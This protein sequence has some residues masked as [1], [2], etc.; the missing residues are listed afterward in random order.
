MP[1]DHFSL[2]VPPSKLEPLVQFLI[3]SLQHLNF[4]EH[5]RPA[6]H[7][8]GMGESMPYFWLAALCSGDTLDEEENTII[9]NIMEKQHVA[10]TAERMG[11]GVATEQVHAFW[12]AAI[13]AGGKGNGPPGPRPQY[14]PG[15]Y[16]AFV[17]DPVCGVN[18]EVV[19]HGY[20]GGEGGDEGGVRGG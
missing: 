9:D 19:C 20:V 17:R 8:V 1:L 14:H 10:F 12:D 7:V 6:P 11:V 18:F 5:M 4:K 3:A 15:Y 13:E 16:A 2:T